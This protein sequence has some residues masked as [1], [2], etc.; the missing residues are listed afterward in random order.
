MA[1]VILGG[2]GAPQKIVTQGYGPDPGP[3]TPAVTPTTSS[4]T[5]LLLAIKARVVASG[6]YFLNQA[7]VT[8]DPDPWPTQAGP[9]ACIRP[10]AHRLDDGQWLGAGAN[11][12]G[13][14]GIV[15]VRVFDQRTSDLVGHDDVALLT[16]DVGLLDRGLA[17][18]EA[19]TSDDAE[20]WFLTQGVVQRGLVPRG[21]KEPTYRKAGK[22]DR[23]W[24]GVDLDF[25]AD[26]THVYRNSS[27]GGG[28]GVVVLPTL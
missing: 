22:E 5:S 14:S 20:G 2:F 4:L 24:R 25:Q 8:L 26:W 1:N 6:L 16:P 9:C 3:V 12:A 11:L 13:Y 28:S 17:L 23:R 10:G 27:Q 7:W 15:T 18:I 21:I 19:L